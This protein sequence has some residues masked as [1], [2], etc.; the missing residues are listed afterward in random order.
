MNPP[1]VRYL[2]E[3]N[4][5]MSRLQPMGEIVVTKERGKKPESI[6]VGAGAAGAGAGAGSG[7]STELVASGAEEGKQM[8]LGLLPDDVVDQFPAFREYVRDQNDTIALSQIEWLRRLKNYIEDANLPPDDQ[9]R[10]PRGSLLLLRL[11][12]CVVTGFDSDAVPQVL[13]HHSV[14]RHR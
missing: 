6:G 7:S 9:V 5:A 14:G 1:V 12:G 4:D 3:V 13:G 10:D 2:L 8:V 11:L